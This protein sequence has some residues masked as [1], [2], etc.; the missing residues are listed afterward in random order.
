MSN[1]KITNDLKNVHFVLPITKEISKEIK[2]STPSYVSGQDFTNLIIFIQQDSLIGII[3]S[4]F[5]LRMCR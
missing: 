3:L 5:R 4:I 2:F 1:L